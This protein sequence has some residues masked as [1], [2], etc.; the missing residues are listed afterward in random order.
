[1]GKQPHSKETN[2][3]KGTLQNKMELGGFVPESLEG[4]WEEGKRN[5]IFGK[6]ATTCQKRGGGGSFTKKETEENKDATST[7]GFVGQ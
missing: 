1:L 3:K 6:P 2:V 7:T 5:D 4:V